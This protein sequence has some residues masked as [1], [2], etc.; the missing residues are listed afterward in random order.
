VLRSGIDEIAGCRLVLTSVF[1]AVA[2]VRWIL[3][4]SFLFQVGVEGR[5]VGGRI[6]EQHVTGL[7]TVSRTDS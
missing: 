2:V 1:A 5:V 3:G 4:S 6:N 7:N